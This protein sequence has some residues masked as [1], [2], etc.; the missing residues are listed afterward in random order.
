MDTIIAYRVADGLLQ[1]IRDEDEEVRIFT[2]KAV[3]LLYAMDNRL[4]DSGQARY[5][6][7]KLDEL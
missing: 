4:F 1:F 5:Q 3:A 7:I 2:D 6:I